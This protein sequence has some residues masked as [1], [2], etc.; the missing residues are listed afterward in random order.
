MLPTHTVHYNEFFGDLQQ[1]RKHGFSQNTYIILE[2]IKKGNAFMSNCRNNAMPYNN[3][4]TMHTSAPMMRRD[5][6]NDKAL[7]MAYVPWQ[8]FGQTYDLSKALC[9]GTIFPELDKPFC[10]KRGVCK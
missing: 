4:R 10:G 1:K 3:Y 6:W 8:R 9:A 7:A 2:Y 5:V